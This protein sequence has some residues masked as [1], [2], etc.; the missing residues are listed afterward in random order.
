MQGSLIQLATAINL[1]HKEPKKQARDDKPPKQ[2][3]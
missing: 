1:V 2:V 3:V